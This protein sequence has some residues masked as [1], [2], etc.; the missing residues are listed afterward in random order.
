[1]K[2]RKFSFVAIC[3]L[4]LSSC[5][6][7]SLNPFYTAKSISFD[8][9]LIGNWTDKSKGR[10]Q[11]VS[12]ESMMEKDSTTNKIEESEKKMYK[13]YKESYYITREYK[14]KE[15]NYIVTPF[16]IKGESFLN[17]FPFENQDD[18]DVL[19]EK[20][21]IYT[22]SLVK[23][24]IDKEGRL[25]IRWLDEDKIEALFEQK[26]IKIQHHKIGLLKDKYLLSASSEDLE[27]FIEK[28]IG[29]NDEEKWKTDTK[30]TLTR[31]TDVE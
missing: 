28:Y 2:I 25:S 8:K 20:H 16:K 27:K 14:G 18:V 23:Y 19:L 1:M 9:R 24:E 12:V 17:F 31:A 21:T 15:T 29:S 11:I 13:A 22:H 30:Y 6:V 7:K 10:W 3:I 4:I 5:V 26:K